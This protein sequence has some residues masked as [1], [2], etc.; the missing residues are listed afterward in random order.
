MYG[1]TFCSMYLSHKNADDGFLPFVAATVRLAI[2]IF[3]ELTSNHCLQ[4]PYYYNFTDSNTSRVSFP[5]L[6]SLRAPLLK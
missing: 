4:Q 6:L 2:I 3:R 5:A 1:P